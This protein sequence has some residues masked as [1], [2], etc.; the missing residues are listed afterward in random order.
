MR[1]SLEGYYC[2]KRL[3]VLSIYGGVSMIQCLMLIIPLLSFTLHT[4]AI[5]FCLWTAT[6][7]TS[8]VQNVIKE[9]AWILNVTIKKNKEEEEEG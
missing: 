2:F 7:P 9:T 1:S 5:C 6:K 8:N 4:Y 3:G